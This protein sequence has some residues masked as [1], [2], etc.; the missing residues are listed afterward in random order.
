MMQKAICFM[1]VVLVVELFVVSGYT[2]SC[3][4]DTSAPQK[5]S[6]NSVKS[7]CAVDQPAAKPI[8]DCCCG[9]ANLTAEQKKISM[10]SLDYGVWALAYVSNSLGV[11][12]PESEVRKLVVPI[13]GKGATMQNIAK[14]ARTMGLAVKGYQVS[15]PE[16][17]QIQKPIIVY[18]PNHFMVLTA[19][20]ANSNKLSLADSSKPKIE[21]QKDEFLSIWQGYVLEIK[22]PEA[23][24]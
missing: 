8:A 11:K 12:K 6:S 23:R 19:I 24:S 1:V 2:E 20:D 7:C 10:Q 15:Y 3:S 17:I 13:P 22:K 4:C 21:M 18:I 14:A 5:D 9:G 16:L